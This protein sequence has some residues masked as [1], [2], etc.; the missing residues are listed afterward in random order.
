M[1]KEWKVGVVNTVTQAAA[2]INE[3]FA[4]QLPGAKVYDII[5]TTMVA[6]IIETIEP[7]PDLTARLAY[8]YQVCEQRGCDCILNACSSISGAVDVAEKTVAIPVFQI[9]RPM[10]DLAV[11]AGRSVGL[12]AT[13]IST[14]TPS[15]K[16]FIRA[17]EEARLSDVRIRTY[18]C[19]GAHRAYIMNGDRATHD[20]IV[21]DAAKEAGA[22]ND[23]LALAQGSMAYLAPRIRELT[24]RPVFTSIES[25]VGQ[26]RDYLLAKAAES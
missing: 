1:D 19:D 12:L 18:Y 22:E 7:R 20:R 24:G 26:V 10:A 8:Y 4:R 2:S 9:D 23:V 15:E 17:K 5:D 11:R 13:A 3:E 25:G 16:L 14:V 21:L 6:E